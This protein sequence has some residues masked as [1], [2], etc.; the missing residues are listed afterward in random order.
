MSPK[1]MKYYYT[2]ELL[3]DEANLAAKS[4]TFVFSVLIFVSH[5]LDAYQCTHMVLEYS[6][7]PDD[8]AAR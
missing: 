7:G 5:T 1:R 3:G 4:T 2:L 8:F 6:G